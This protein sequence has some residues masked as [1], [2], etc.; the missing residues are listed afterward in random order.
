M[1]ELIELKKEVKKRRLKIFYDLLDRWEEDLKLS[2]ELSKLEGN[3]HL[4]ERA[5][6]QSSYAVQLRS[7][8]EDLKA[9]LEDA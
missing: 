6:R 1:D 8:I 3:T 9:V 5:S 4:Q 2:V 7:C